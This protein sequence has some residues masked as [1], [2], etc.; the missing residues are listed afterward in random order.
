MACGGTEVSEKICIVEVSQVTIFDW[1]EEEWAFPF[2][3]LFLIIKKQVCIE[4][5][6]QK[7]KKKNS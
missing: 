1:E 6:M 4:K 3:Y 5:E 2:I 7:K